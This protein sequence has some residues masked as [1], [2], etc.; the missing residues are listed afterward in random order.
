MITFNE[1]ENHMRY[2]TLLFGAE[3]FKPSVYFT[4]STYGFVPAVSPEL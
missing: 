1:C 3:S 4:S 2:L